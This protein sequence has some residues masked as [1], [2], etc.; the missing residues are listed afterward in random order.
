L[1][2]LLVPCEASASL[3]GSR[4]LV[5]APH[6]DDEVFGCGGA[7][8]RH[9]AQGAALTVVIVTDGAYGVAEEQANAVRA[10]RQQESRVAAAVLGYGEPRFLGLPDRGLHYGEALIG[11]VQGL[12]DETQAD[13]VYAPSLHE[14]HPDHRS[15]AMATLE[16]V[17]RAGGERRLAFYEVGIPLTPSHLID[18]TPVLA[19][20]A[21][22]VACFPSQLLQQ[23]YDQH[24]AALNRY[25]TYTLP[26]EIVAAEAFEVIEAHTLAHNPLSPYRSEYQK[27]RALGLPMASVDLPLVSVLVRSMDRDAL[28]QALD[29]VALQTYSNI[30]VVV[31][32][33]SGQA[34]R[35]LGEWCGRFPLRL[36][37]PGVP[38][39][40]SAAANAALDAARGELLVFLDDDDYYLPSHIAALKAGLDAA[41]LATIAVYAGVSCVDAQGVEVRRYQRDFDRL[42]FAIE[43]FIPIHA[44]LF[45][46]R[47]L[48][49]GA[50]F[51][52]Q[53][54][55]CE[56]WDFWL[57]VQDHGAFRLVPELGALYRVGAGEGSDLWD[58][59]DLARPAMLRVYRKRLPTWSDAQ[60]WHWYE[61][62]RYKPLYEQIHDELVSAKQHAAVLEH[63]RNQ[64]QQQF[65]A[66]QDHVAA[67]QEHREALQ[68][69]LAALQEHLQA[70]ETAFAANIAERDAYIAAL[71]GSTSWK[72]TAPL[73][74]VM[75]LLRGAPKHPQ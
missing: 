31:V 27:Q 52:E 58:N 34:H 69:H 71:L 2:I 54:T 39:N 41:G 11:I 10:M 25:R 59:V 46:R 21:E 61:L 5:L 13:L 74:K 51:D 19:R 57:Q 40:R 37:E 70:S 4:I 29:S 62:T 63:E 15:L 64:A 33:A 67:L 55:H 26:P 72:L 23:R 43:N 42:T 7:L 9:V 56:D 44:V 65:A 48:E 24:I 30:E 53:Q 6:P 75:A 17:R 20:K 35:A 45:R 8:A 28:A 22:A 73:R 16:A 68:A 18:I 32:N 66:E 47:A 1:E 36:I 12:L 38:L 49:R 50:R 60:L 14:M 3:P